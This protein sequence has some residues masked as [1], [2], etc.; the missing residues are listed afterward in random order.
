MD[1]STECTS[2]NNRHEYLT[3]SLG[4]EAY[5]LDILNVQEIR[6][7]EEPTRIANAPDYIRGVIDLRG[8]IVPIVDLRIKFNSGQYDYTPM[9]VAIILTIG[10]QLIGIIVDTVSDVVFLGP[11]QIR[12]VPSFGATV[13]TS[14]IRGMAQQDD[15]TL[16]VI[17]IEKL[18]EA[19]EILAIG[20]AA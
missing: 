12:P 1:Q 14:Y 6:N 10:Q 15:R 4:H 11:E 5:A 8:I 3:F 13:D 16:M 9:T 2:A 20:K 18:I 7:Y 17:Y 19:G